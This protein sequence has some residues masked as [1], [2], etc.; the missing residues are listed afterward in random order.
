MRADRSSNEAADWAANGCP[1]EGAETAHHKGKS[2]A[3][4]LAFLERRRGVFI[5][6]HLAIVLAVSLAEGRN[7][8]LVL[9]IRDRPALISYDRLTTVLCE[10]FDGSRNIRCHLMV[11]DG[12]LQRRML[13]REKLG[14]E[15]FAAFHP[16]KQT[17]IFPDI[18]NMVYETLVA[19]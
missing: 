15:V 2:A 8:A 16:L 10:A 18:G 12:F 17:L 4:F 14:A 3:F 11:G 7:G 13:F 9:D 1:Y 6:N 19:V 5:R